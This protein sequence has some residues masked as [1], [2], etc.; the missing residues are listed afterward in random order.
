[1]RGH[2][3]QN[4][5]PHA[6]LPPS[7]LGMDAWMTSQL[8][9]VLIHKLRG[10]LICLARYFEMLFIDVYTTRHRHTSGRLVQESNVDTVTGQYVTVTVL[11]TLAHAGVDN[12]SLRC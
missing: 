5:R 1:M 10:S 3:E 2:P 6:R 11:K 7:L 4:T 8:N 9:V 12:L